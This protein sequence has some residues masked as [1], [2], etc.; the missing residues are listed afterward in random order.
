M[1]LKNILLDAVDQLEKAQA[2]AEQQL[3]TAKAD[4]VV[5]TE[6]QAA[7][8]KATK[9]ADKARQRLQE[10]QDMV[11]LGDS[12]SGREKA[13]KQVEVDQKLKS[14]DLAKW[15]NKLFDIQ[16]RQE[17]KDKE[18]IERERAVSVRERDYKATAQQEIVAGLVKNLVSK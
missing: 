14:N 7:A 1:S 13:V 17:A 3:T 11:N 10:A 15:E 8:N 6:Q 5:A 2:A 9:E 18:L 16:T 4:Q 12:L